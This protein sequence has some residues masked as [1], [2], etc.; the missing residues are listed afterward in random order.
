M[1]YDNKTRI[2]AGRSCSIPQRQ[3]H[4][5]NSSALQQW[6]AHGRPHLSSYGTKSGQ[7]QARSRRSSEQLQASS[8]AASEQSTRQRE[9]EPSHDEASVTAQGQQMAKKNK[10]D[11]DEWDMLEHD[12]E[13]C[14]TNLI[15]A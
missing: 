5:K 6:V 10:E 11:N 1:N 3:H 9:V 8:R 4:R 2:S 15:T 13:V 14:P 12:D 7:T